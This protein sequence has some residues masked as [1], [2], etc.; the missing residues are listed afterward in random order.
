MKPVP[1]LGTGTQ[2]NTR[3]ALMQPAPDHQEEVW[4]VGKATRRIRDAG[5]IVEVVQ[6]SRVKRS[7]GAAV[8]KAKR[9]AT[10]EIMQHYN[11]K[12]SIRKFELMLAA[13]FRAGDIVGC[14]T[15]DDARLPGSRKE[16]ERRFRYFR[17][18]LKR[19]YAALGVELVMF[20]STEHKHGDARWHHHFVVTA[21]GDDYKRIRAAWI[22][23]EVQ[24]FSA[25]Q[26]GEEKNY[27][28]IAEYFAK[29][30]REKIGLRSWSYTRNARKPAEE[31]GVV[32][33]HDAPKIP[34]GVIVLESITSETSF[35]RHYYQKYMLP[36][37]AQLPR[38]R[39]KRKRRQT[40]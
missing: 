24:E 38:K 34:E 17:D 20:W 30:S 11:R 40:V 35:G 26:V 4:P 39:A 31:W 37:A 16:A 5:A 19:Q 15:Y 33:E 12:S 10:S 28:T 23:G 6:Y 25:L 14:V 7:D 2:T 18:K 13:N 22:Y 9:K 27:R 32:D 21:T 3:P 36:A 8:R 1:D 29:E